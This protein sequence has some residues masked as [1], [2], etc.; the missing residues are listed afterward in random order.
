MSTCSTL[1]EAR[2]A[3]G[4]TYR[5]VSLASGLPLTALAH[6]ERG[7]RTPGPTALARWQDGLKQLLAER[8]AKIVDVL[9]HF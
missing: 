3:A 1:R 6:Y 9:V 2:Q 4:L 5:Q 7:A 8:I